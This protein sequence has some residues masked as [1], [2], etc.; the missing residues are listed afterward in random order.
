MMEKRLQN[1]FALVRTITNLKLSI[2]HRYSRSIDSQQCIE[3]MT[4]RRCVHRNSR[5]RIICIDTDYTI[6]WII[7]NLT[8]ALS[9]SVGV[10]LTGQLAL[11]SSRGRGVGWKS[12]YKDFHQRGRRTIWF[13]P[14]KLV[15]VDRR[16]TSSNMRGIACKSHPK[17]AN[18]WTGGQQGRN[19]YRLPILAGEGT[20]I[21]RRSSP[22]WV[23]LWKHLSIWLHFPLFQS[24]NLSHPWSI[25]AGRQR[26]YYR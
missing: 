7:K 2:V 24:R 8:S 9:V 23:M 18:N 4:D 12:M 16:T 1:I 22:F 11:L 14:N 10:K 6:R 25:H 17:K 20:P 5:K 13:L 3:I 15:L 26:T 21:A 19:T